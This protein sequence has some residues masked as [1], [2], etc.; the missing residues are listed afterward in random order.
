MTNEVQ[1]DIPGEYSQYLLRVTEY[2]AD[3]GKYRQAKTELVKKAAERVRQAT[4]RRRE[5]AKKLAHA[6]M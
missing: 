6:L 4:E 1:W 2:E 3:L 5:R